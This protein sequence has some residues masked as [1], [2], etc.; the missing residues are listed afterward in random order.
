MTTKAQNLR[1]L[2]NSKEALV[3]P[4]AF[5]CVSA[6]LIEKIGFHAVYMTGFGVSASL[7]GK[8][9]IGLVTLPEMAGQAGNIAASIDIPLIADADTGYGN[10]LNVARTIELY[11]RTGIAAIQLEDQGFPKKCGHMEDK[12][13]ISKEEAT[14]KIRAAV[15]ARSNPDTVLIARTDARS[16]V[17]LKEAVERAKAYADAG[18]DVIFVESPLSV[19]E[20]E[21]ISHKLK[22]ISL[23]ANM[24]EGGKVLY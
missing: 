17:G 18:A 19:D 3:A 14:L 24:V 20:M 13:L 22:G 6:R 8:P 4:G 9:D 7:I 10:E 5:D 2:L 1:Q 16:V 23:M 21:Y 12:T 11:E 15:N